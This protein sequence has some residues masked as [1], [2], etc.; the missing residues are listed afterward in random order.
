M[1]IHTYVCMHIYTHAHI[2]ICICMYVCVYIYIYICTRTHTSMLIV[3]LVYRT[4]VDIL[5][6]YSVG[7]TCPTPIV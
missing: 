2:H 6:V 7:T 1:C 5:I 3:Q 4:G